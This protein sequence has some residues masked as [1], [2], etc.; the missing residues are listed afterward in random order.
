VHARSARAR[1]VL[2]FAI[3]SQAYRLGE[4]NMF[5]E[6]SAVTY[7]ELDLANRSQ[8]Y[9]LQELLHVAVYEDGENCVQ[10]QYQVRRVCRAIRLSIS[11]L[12]ALS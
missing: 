12:L 10:L 5:A 2:T 3:F 1:V 4:E 8:R 9:V 11:Q 7:Y 6:A